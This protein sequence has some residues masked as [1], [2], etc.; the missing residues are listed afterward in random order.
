M[1]Q[2]MRRQQKPARQMAPARHRWVGARH[3]QRRVYIASSGVPVPLEIVI[4][5]HGC[6]GNPL[7]LGQGLLVPH[8]L[9]KKT[10]GITQVA[11]TT[12]R[13]A[14]KHSAG[15]IR[16]CSTQHSVLVAANASIYANTSC[17]TQQTHLSPHESDGSQSIQ[18]LGQTLS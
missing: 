14:G 18:W 8:T 13:P 11:T 17:S 16:G 1:P 7:A 2:E 6:T 12:T 9:D 4:Q 15:C 5:M 3:M 10:M